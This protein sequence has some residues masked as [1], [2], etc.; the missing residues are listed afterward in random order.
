MN[1]VD[2]VLAFEDVN[3]PLLLRRWFAGF[4]WFM[5]LEDSIRASDSVCFLC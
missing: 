2:S 1:V 3:A 4:W 5:I